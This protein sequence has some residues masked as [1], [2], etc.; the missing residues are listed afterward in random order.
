MTLPSAS[1]HDPTGAPLS[2]H[3]ATFSRLTASS[4]TGVGA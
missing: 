1:K 4:G 2:E 3:G